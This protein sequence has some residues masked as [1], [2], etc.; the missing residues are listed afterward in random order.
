VWLVDFPIFGPRDAS[1]DGVVA[2]AEL[3]PNKIS[4]ASAG[5][6]ILLLMVIYPLLGPALEL[7]DRT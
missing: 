4:A 2:Y 5:T 6:T 7:G 1:A 3:A